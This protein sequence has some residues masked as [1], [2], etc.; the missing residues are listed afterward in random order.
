LSGLLAFPID[1]FVAFYDPSRDRGPEPIL[2]PLLITKPVDMSSLVASS[3]GGLDGAFCKVMEIEGEFFVSVTVEKAK[4]AGGVAGLVV[5][6]DEQRG[7]LAHLPC[8]IK[9][10]QRIELSPQLLTS[11]WSEEEKAYVGRAFVKINRPEDAIDSSG[12]D[13]RVRLEMG[14][15]EGMFSVH[16]KSIGTKNAIHRIDFKFRPHEREPGQAALSELSVVWEITVG[17]VNQ[18]IETTLRVFPPFPNSEDT[19]KE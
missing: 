13:N 14:S 6:R 8:V 7:L 16:A 18:R 19:R 11:R 2:I 3:S 17:K 9:E 5:V 1:Q 4:V 15:G 10:V 12:K